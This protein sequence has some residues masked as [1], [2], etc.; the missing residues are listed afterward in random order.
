MSHDL[1][2]RI[3]QIGHE[4]LVIGAQDDQITPFGFSEEL[5]D[6]IPNATLHKLDKGGHFC[7]MANMRAYNRA[8][9]AF[10]RK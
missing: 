7:P 8:V 10:L 2:S 3:H 6:K 4:T 9:L 1:R 5:A